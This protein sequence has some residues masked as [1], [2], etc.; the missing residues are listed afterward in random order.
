MNNFKTEL[1]THLKEICNKLKNS[2]L[3]THT[4]LFKFTIILMWPTIADSTILTNTLELIQY[5][6]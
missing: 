4:Y 5:K 3:F 1:N 2:N 6:L